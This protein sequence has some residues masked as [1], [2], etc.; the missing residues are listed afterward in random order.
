VGLPEQLEPQAKVQLEPQ[1]Y[2]ELTELQV[3]QDCA[4]LLAAQARQETKAQLGRKV[5]LA[6]AQAEQ[7]EPLVNKGQ[8]A[9]KV[10]PEVSA[11]AEQLD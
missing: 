3:L 11:L 9:H 5:L 4:E 1:D 10:P 6:S 7:R 8:S 2:R